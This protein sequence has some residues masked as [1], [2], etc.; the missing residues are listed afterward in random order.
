MT[1][2]QMANKAWPWKTS[3]HHG[4]SKAYQAL[5]D[6]GEFQVTGGKG[7]SEEKLYRLRVW[8]R[9][10]RENDYVLEFDPELPAIP[11]VAPFGGFAYRKRHKSDGDLLIR[12]NEHTNLTEQGKMIW[13]YPPSDP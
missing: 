2:R 11:G 5:R 1:P 6:L 8:L 10:M 9:N 4:K 7:M 13:R 3:N 12:V